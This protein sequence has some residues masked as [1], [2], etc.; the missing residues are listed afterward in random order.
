MG[1]ER[2][3]ESEIGGAVNMRTERCAAVVVAA[4]RGTR[5]GGSL[6]KQFLDLGGKPLV[7]YA[8]KCLQDSEYIDEIIL[9]TGAESIDYCRREI[10]EKFGLSKVREI[11]AGGRERYDSVYEGLKRCQDA[12]YV[13]IHDGARPFI[14]EEI[15]KR[16]LDGAKK[17]GAC[18]VGMPSKDTVKLADEEGYVKET[19]ARNL[20]WT[21][22]T[23]QV[24]R[25]SLI[26]KAYESMQSKD[27]T[28]VTDDACVVEQETGVKIWLAEG[29]YKNIKITTPED[30]LIAK[31][32]LEEEAD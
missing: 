14:S 12:D 22:Q 4:G 17:T 6:Q 2:G 29:S 21:V 31:A 19:P 1:S 13:F 15:I 10:I 30:L 5:M 18:V 27:M 24:F 16:G 3:S 20:V 23:P 9:V 7:Y 28:A 25:Y 8:L 32:F 11:A 26:R